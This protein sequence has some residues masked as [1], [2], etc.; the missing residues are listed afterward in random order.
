MSF[1]IKISELLEKFNLE[2]SEKGN[3][4]RLFEYTNFLYDEE[5]NLTKTFNLVKKARENLRERIKELFESNLIQ[6]DLI[7]ES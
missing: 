6:E 4:I 2:E 3:L 7:Q 1:E 5:Y